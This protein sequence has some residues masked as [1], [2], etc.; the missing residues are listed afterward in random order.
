[1]WLCGGGWIA[2]SQSP[3]ATEEQCPSRQP[4]DLL[5]LLVMLPFP[6]P[7][8]G[9]NPSW[10]EAPN[11]L[12]ALYLAADQ[13]NNRSDILPC[14]QLELLVVD[15]GCDI[16]AT[17][18]YSAAV[19]LIG[20]DGRMARVVGVVG[21]GCSSSTLQT[22]HTLNQP[23]IE[24]IHI[25]DAGTPLLSDRDKYTNSLGILGS[26]QSFVDLSLALMWKSDWRNI[27]IL[28]E[29]NRVYFR[30]TKEAFVASLNSDVNLL[31]SS[32]VYTTFY[33]LDGIRSSLARIV[34]I[35][36]ETS[37]SLRIM[38]LAYHMGMVYP[39]YQWVFISHRLTDFIGENTNLSDSITFSYNRQTYSCALDNLLNTAL[40]GSFLL[41]YQLESLSSNETRKLANTTFEEFQQL[42]EER[43]TLENATVTYWAYNLYDAIWAWARVLHR[44]TVDNND[45]F[46]NDYEYGNRTLANAILNEFYARD[47]EFEGMSGLISFNS[48]N[49]FYD[50]PSNLYQV[51]GGEETH[52]AYN[53]GTS[54]MKIRP[55]VIVPDQVRVTGLVNIEV[56]VIFAIVQLLE[57]I[58]L[59]V[60]H[61][62]TVVYRNEPTVRAS[63]PKLSHFAFVGSYLLIFGLMLFVFVEI[64]VHSAEVSGP[65]CQTI[66]G[67]L[68]PIGFTLTIG[69][70]TIRTWRLYRIFTHYLNPGKLIS[71]TALITMIVILLSVDI[72]IA[73]IWT[74]FDPLRLIIVEYPVQV[75][76]A[77]ELI[78]DRSCRSQAAGLE[79]FVWWII[80][81]SIRVT[82][83]I[84]MVVL[85]VQ[86]RRIPNKTFTTSSLRI[87][88]YIISA[89]FVLGV[90]LYYMFIF[91]SFNP[92]I[93]FSI[94]CIV[95]N[96]LIL[97][98]MACVFVPP[99]APVLH[100]KIQKTRDSGKTPFQA[101]H[102]MDW[103]KHNQY[104]NN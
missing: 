59:I 51:V 4:P 87:F 99:L 63:S 68:F 79:G 15:G 40:E 84:V 17:T 36:T 53:N 102:S 62:L 85:S 94:L 42:Y 12:P 32:P 33:P 98:Y 41:N 11:I 30:S 104:T 89:V 50:R 52:V 60:L 16:A 70:V 78:L 26:T 29:S 28:F 23:D 71:N 18:A 65:V 92:N 7:I 20:N 67:W 69:T 74:A 61:V 25:H 2:E 3:S 24:L 6:N 96:L 21:P 64:R 86:T 55:L 88:S 10:T 72:I 27:A 8:P 22:A 83:L 19:G 100:A 95:L 58:A 93:D 97:L 37:H 80:V 5:Q 101:T 47:F 82:E 13:I 103:T 77:S 91:L 31:F 38:C 56:I 54:I 9:F 39:A 48:S 90:V 43:A 45:L 35:F 34:F 1:V 75:G 44:I 49:G 66:W 81:M 57:F 73:I 76:P 46:N 14:L